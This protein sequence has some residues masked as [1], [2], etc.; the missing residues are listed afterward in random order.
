M[1]FI[2]LLLCAVSL[3]TYC[4]S[5]EVENPANNA[6]SST[7][8]VDEQI[9]ALN[10]ELIIHNED[11]GFSPSYWQIKYDSDKKVVM[12]SNY[13]KG[14]QSLIYTNTVDPKKIRLII[15]IE[16]SSGHCIRISAIDKAIKSKGSSD[17]VVY[18]DEFTLWMLQGTELEINKIKND[19]V[20]L[21]R[22]LGSSLPD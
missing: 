4:F 22:R 13:D 15:E 3:S 20:K 2:L 7:A 1:K 21:F 17:N 11:M 19:L 12:M 9:N 14:S 10:A 6:L 16:K 5:Q 8:N 18:E